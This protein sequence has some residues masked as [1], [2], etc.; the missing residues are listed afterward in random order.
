MKIAILGAV[1]IKH[2]TLISH[3]LDN[4]D[5]NKH[6]VDIIH[7][8]KYGIDEKVDRVKTH[9]FNIE[10]NS[11]WSLLMKAIKYYQFK[12]FAEKIIKDNEYD[13]IIVWGTY[14]GH[15]FSRFL[16][17]NYDNKYILNIRDYFYENNKIIYFLLKRLIKHSYFVTLSSEGFYKFLPSSNKYKVIYSINKKI[18]DEANM[19]NG[20]KQ[21]PPIRISFI[22][23][24]RF[25][26]VNKAFITNLKNDSRF[27]LKYFGTGSQPLKEYCV[28]ENISNV[29][30]RDGFDVKET[31]ALLDETDIINNIYGNNNIALNTA[32]SIRLYYSIFLNIPILT[33]T[34]TFTA[35]LAKKLELGYEIDPKNMTNIGDEI[36][37]WYHSLNMLEIKKRTNLEKEKIQEHN[38]DFYLSFKRMLNNEGL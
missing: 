15:L 31:A 37:Q 20:I 26:D 6:E 28:E 29:V 30:F 11:K 9:K 33:S 10:I 16:I 4:I 32:L 1:N 35:E 27:I 23:N 21:D 13:L 24:I 14:T 3:Y 36:Y 2:M 8:D 17:K 25:L 5:F 34:N 18:T 7:I 19:R 12:P 22:G 38:E